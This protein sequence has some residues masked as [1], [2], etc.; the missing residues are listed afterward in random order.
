VKFGKK[1]KSF[2]GRSRRGLLNHRFLLIGAAA[3]V[4]AL[5]LL[6]QFGE[7]G[8]AS[9]W[10]L[11]GEEAQLRQEVARLQAANADLEAR[12][13]ALAN[14]PEALEKLAR[15]QHSMRLKDEEVLTVLD[16]TTEAKSTGN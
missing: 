3:A 10:K 12:L 2:S 7:T 6:G 16:R 11:R 15:E 9:F 4:A 13:E 8:V 1:K 5:I 14:D